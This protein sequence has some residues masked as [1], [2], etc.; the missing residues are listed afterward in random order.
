MDGTKYTE[1]ADKKSMA[2]ERSFE[3]PVKNVWEAWTKKELLEKWWAPAPWKAVTK[4]FDFRKGGK[5][6]Y[7]MTGPKGERMWNLEEYLEVDQEKSFEARDFFCDEDGIPSA[8][9][10]ATHWR[11]EF[12]G[13]GG[14]TRVTLHMTCESPKDLQE[15]TDMGFKEGFSQALEQLEALLSE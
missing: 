8:E 14:Q 15:L 6:L 5:W 12:D 10:P 1:G 11:V 3:A 2:I 4:T 7:A 9:M 13:V